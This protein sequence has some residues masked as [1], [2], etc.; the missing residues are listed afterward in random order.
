MTR[1]PQP[2]RAVPADPALMTATELLACYRQRSLSPIEATHACLGRI[3][4]H[5]ASV[6]AYCLVDEEAA[7]D[8]AASAEE[9]WR[10][11]LSVGALDGVPI[12][13]KDV[14][15]VRGWPTRKG[16]H[17]SPADSAAEDAPVVAALRRHGAVML[18]KT[19]TPELGWKGVTD[20]PLC[21]ITRN[22]WDRSRTP[23][24]SS[25]G[26]SVAVALGMGPLALGTDGGGSIRIPAALSGIVGHK[27]TQGRVPMW[28][29]S[30]FGVLAHI[31]L[32]TWT[33]RDAALL[34]N[35]LA[36]P[37][38]RDPQL[39]AGPPVDQ[40]AGIDDG[41]AGLRVAFVPH[42]G[43][44]VQV[45]GDVAARVSEAAR[46]F[47][48]LG[49]QV[50]EVALDLGQ[51]RETFETLWY[52]GA[53]HAVRAISPDD[54]ARLDPGLLEIA[55]Q[56]ARVSATDLLV[57]EDRR[58]ALV[59]KLSRFHRRFPL[60]IA[61]TVPIPAFEAGRE[62]PEGW[63]D[64]RWQSWTPWTYPFNLT[65]Q[66]AASVP[67]GWTRAGLPVGLQ[68]IGARHQDALVLRAAHSY[69]CARPLT[70][71]R[72]PSDHPCRNR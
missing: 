58:L 9:R 18:G 10:R 30:P 31:G 38:F 21:G 70:H 54:R 19:T 47:E 67:C 62:V 65:G 3:R 43:G 14:L 26:S 24:G 15:A 49:A 44:D 59:E 33:V 35:V 11:G 51:S 39:P 69:Q 28:P 40:L 17:L 56:G 71:R 25:G 53:A 16:S 64:P 4:E 63:P 36:E 41:V 45:D 61:P 46:V 52:A 22:P 57:A 27:P 68:I 60:L 23:G 7:L 34:M 20:S 55:C 72:P 6:L 8:A 1:D 12:A 37:D 13:I 42:L 2:T 32:M 48:E 29:R 66:P 5:N 50:E